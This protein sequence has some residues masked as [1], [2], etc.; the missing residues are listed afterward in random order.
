MIAVGQSADEAILNYIHNAGACEFE[1]GSNSLKVYVGVEGY[2]WREGLLPKGQS[3]LR[4]RHGEL[5]DGLK[6]AAEGIVHISAL[7]G[8]QNN[9]AVVRFHPL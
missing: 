6:T 4:P 2:I 7:V 5:N 9:Q 8:G 1:A 3:L